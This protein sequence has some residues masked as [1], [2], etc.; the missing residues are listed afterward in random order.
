MDR[1]LCLGSLAKDI[2][3]YGVGGE[4]NERKRGER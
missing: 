3:T 2:T 4:N 1:E